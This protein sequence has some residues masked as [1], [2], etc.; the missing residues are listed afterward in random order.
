MDSRH[1]LLV[2]HNLVKDL[3]LDGPNQGWAA[4]I[5]YIRTEEGFLYL[6][7]LIDLWS[8]KIVDYHAG[9]TLEA[10]GVLRALE[11]ALTELPQGAFPVH[12]S[13]RGCQYYSHRYVGK[14]RGRGGLPS[15]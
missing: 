4:D 7:P 14:L 11:M 9:D 6:S 15:V 5:T 10:E 13:D 8:R 2:F 12:H 1:S 3:T